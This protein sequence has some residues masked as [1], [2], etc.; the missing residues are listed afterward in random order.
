M[1]RRERHVREQHTLPATAASLQR[2]LF[3]CSTTT[4]MAMATELLLLGQA[5]LAVPYTL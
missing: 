3:A 1:H 5:T 4:G 2:T